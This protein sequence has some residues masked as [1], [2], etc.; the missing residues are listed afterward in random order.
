MFVASCEI[1]TPPICHFCGWCSLPKILMFILL[2]V[3]YTSV[4]AVD[5]EGTRHLCAIVWSVLL[6]LSLK[7]L[8]IFDDLFSSFFLKFLKA[9]LSSVGWNLWFVPMPVTTITKKL[10]QTYHLHWKLQGPID[11]T[12]HG[13]SHLFFHLCQKPQTSSSNHHQITM[14][15]FL[16]VFKST[17]V[18]VENLWR[19]L[20]HPQIRSSRIRISGLPNS[21]VVPSIARPRS[22][23]APQL[24]HQWWTPDRSSWP[25]SSVRATPWYPSHPMDEAWLSI[26]TH[27]DDWGYPP[28]KKARCQEVSIN[29]NESAERNAV[30]REKTLHTTSGNSGKHGRNRCLWTL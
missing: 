22:A 15:C 2:N 18:K 14:K 11:P 1:Y 29:V 21:E 26:E 27:G 12:K 20:P 24:G 25:S 17:R 5:E 16:N 13:E 7:F 4:N 9:S 6:M 19:L 10:H 3:N 30:E 8:V 28:F 23:E